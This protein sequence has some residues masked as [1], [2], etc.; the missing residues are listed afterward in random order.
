MKATMLEK[1]AAKRRLESSQ[2]KL[3][4]RGR[5]HP[6]VQYPK[7]GSR[8]GMNQPAISPVWSNMY[9][10]YNVDST[11][12]TSRKP[13]NIDPSGKDPESTDKETGSATAEETGPTEENRLT[14]SQSATD[15]VETGN[16]PPT[17]NQSTEAE[18]SS[19]QE[20]LTRDQPDTEQNEDI[21]ETK[22]Q[23]SSPPLNDTNIGPEASFF[24]KVQGPA[25]LPPKIITG[26]QSSESIY[27]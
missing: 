25:R 8:P 27:I 18:T 4:R 14:G 7:S 2:N 17:R 16:E 10:Q 9:H 24:D 20:P 11:S 19:S 6:V 1:L 26:N 22:G 21:P 12:P 15:N 3:T 5:K 23:A 13:S